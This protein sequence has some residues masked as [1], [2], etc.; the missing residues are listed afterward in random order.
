MACRADRAWR[1][2]TAER[3]ARIEAAEA[4]LKSLGYREFR[5]R[6]PKGSWHA[7]RLPPEGLARWSI[8]VCCADLVRRLKE[9]GFSLCDDRPGRISLRQLE[10]MIPLEIRNRNSLKSDGVVP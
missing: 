6:L 5:V 1:R 4:H 7:S 8:R 3:T 2:A 9:L 10:Y